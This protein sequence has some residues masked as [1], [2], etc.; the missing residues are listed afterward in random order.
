MND[1][2][3]DS[4]QP[5]PRIPSHNQVLTTLDRI[6]GSAKFSESAQLS[7]FLRYVVESRLANDGQRLKESVIGVSVFRRAVGYDTKADPIVR[8]EARRLRSR[9]EQYYDENGAADPVRISLP[10]GGYSPEFEAV[11]SPETLV[12]ERPAI[13]DGSEKAKPDG[14]SLRPVAL[15]AVLVILSV[16][17]IYYLLYRSKAPERAASRF[18]SS[19]L[20][21]GRPALIVPADSGLTMLED[22][23]HHP[24]P[25]REYLTGEHRRQLLQQVPVEGTAATF[26]ERRYTP[27]TDLAFAVRLARRPEAAHLGILA[28]YA[29]D[30]RVEDLK[31]SNLIL[32]GPRHMNPWVELFERESTFRVEHDEKTSEYRIVNLKPGPG[33]LRAVTVTLSG[34]RQEVYGIISYHRNREGSGYV[35]ML[36]GTSIA[37][38]EAAADMLLDDAQ[39]VQWLRKAQPGG[40]NKGFDLLLRGQ[41][42]AGSAP[43]AEVVAFHVDS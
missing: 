31:R 8:V 27:Y 29:R 21:A 1:L 32:L 30:I 28:R 39:L 33:E 37:G 24:V 22:L 18:W 16:G 41:N 13:V 17:S 23:T 43:R 3:I 12:S 19:I 11:G 2:Q 38:T 26:T 34:V 14:R 25:L 6:L 36:S 7:R 20:D 4:S 10:K 5:E 35:L 42:L 15:A 9:L 40:E